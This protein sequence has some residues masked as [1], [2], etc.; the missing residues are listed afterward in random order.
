[1]NPSLPG[2]KTTSVS[3][4]LEAIVWFYL[5][6]EKRRITYEKKNRN[7]GT[8]SASGIGAGECSDCAGGEC[9]GRTRIE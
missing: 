4:L 9:G 2:G 8:F 7:T 1:M 3:R 6:F 5:R